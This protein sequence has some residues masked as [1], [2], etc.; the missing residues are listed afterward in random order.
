MLVFFN[1]FA[2]YDGQSRCFVLK[3]VTYMIQFQQ[4]FS[5]SNPAPSIN[6]KKVLH[7]F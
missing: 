2:S 5:L 1:N 4:N 3:T 7:K 6:S